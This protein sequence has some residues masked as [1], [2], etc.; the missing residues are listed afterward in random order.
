MLI[1][2]ITSV[3]HLYTV[4]VQDFLIKKKSLRLLFWWINGRNILINIGRLHCMSLLF[5]FP[6]PKF[7]QSSSE[8]YICREISP[9]TSSDT[10]YKK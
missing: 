1:C 5:N 3:F 10:K 4:H 7:Y 2:D 9:L 8:S 6:Y